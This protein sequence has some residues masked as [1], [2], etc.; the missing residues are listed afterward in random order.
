V[1]P[2]PGAFEIGSP[3]EEQ[4]RFANEERRRVQIDYPFAVAVQLVT[5]AE[6]KKSRPDFKQEWRQSSPGEDTPING[7]TWYDALRYCNWL[8]EQE[9][10]PREQ[11]CYEPNDEG[12]YAEGMKLKANY[13]SLLGYRLPQE[14]EWEYAC[15]T[16]TLTPWAHG[17]EEALL[18]HYAWYGANAGSTMHPVGTRKPNGL[19]LFDMHGN[20]WQWCHET[21]IEKD[22]KYVEYHDKD[23]RIVRGGSFGSVARSTRSTYRDSYKPAVLY[24]SG[25]FRVA[26]TYR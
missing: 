15:R 14:A 10:F 4:S 26:R 9:Q 16:G 17:S 19:G 24:Y 2:A 5:V 3:P 6:F 25:G 13:Q 11:W 22:I 20:A 12:E 1:I 7:V 8:S 23:V 18:S 21:P